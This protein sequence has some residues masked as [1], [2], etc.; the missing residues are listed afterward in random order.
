MNVS[1]T[2]SLAGIEFKNPITTASGTFGFGFDYANIKGFNN[3][4]LGGITL[5]ATTLNPRKGNRPQR[6]IETC[7]GVLNSIGLQNPGVEKVL[8]EYLPKLQKE[9]ES[10]TRIIFNLA[11][12]SYEEYITVAARIAGN[13]VIDAI[14]LNISC[15]N[16][17]EGGIQFG[18]VPRLTEKVVKGVKKE[19]GSIPLLVKLSPNVTDITEI[20]DAALTGGGDAIS[21]INTYTGMAIDVQTRKPALGNRIGGL[22]GPA[23]KPLALY[24]IDKLNQWKRKKNLQFDILGMG[25]IVDEEDILEFLLAGASVISLGTSLFLYEQSIEELL[26]KLTNRMEQLGMHSIK[27]VIGTLES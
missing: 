12:A 10:N 2:T 20:A 22:S 25:G 1:L 11:G 24:Q 13:K 7:G 19:L 4:H 16:V 18:S 3:C 5:K 6:I 8:E 15:P 27:E 26:Q 21:L 14:E 17:K 23:I 9:K